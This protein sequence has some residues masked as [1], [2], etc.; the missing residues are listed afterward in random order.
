MIGKRIRYY[1]NELELPCPH[2]HKM[3]ATGNGV[4][5]ACICGLHFTFRRGHLPM[6]LPPKPDSY[7]ATHGN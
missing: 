5:I 2:C 7:K 4:N 1:W 6:K 3:W